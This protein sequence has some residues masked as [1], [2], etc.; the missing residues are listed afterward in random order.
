M[1]KRLLSVLGG[2][3][4]ASILW[5]APPPKTTQPTLK[6]KVDTVAYAIGVS[7]GYSMQ[8]GLA[9]FPGPKLDSKIILTG[10]Q[11]VLSGEKPSLSAEEAEELLRSYFEEIQKKKDEENKAKGEEFL[12][13]NAKKAGVKSTK[14]GLQYTILREGTG[15]HPTVEDTVVVHYTG[16]T[17]DGNVFD[18]SVERGEPAEFQLLQVIPGW[19]EGLCLLSKGAKAILYIPHQLAYGD[20]GAGQFIAPYSTLIFEVELIDVKKGEPIP[21]AGADPE[22][23]TKKKEKAK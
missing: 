6:S 13:S 15:E 21:I 11:Q 10:L 17:I 4:C 3:F 18:S 19:T 14:S 5:A 8:N 1:K 7:T 20:R 12:A 2:C 23:A 9:T 22:K 16:K